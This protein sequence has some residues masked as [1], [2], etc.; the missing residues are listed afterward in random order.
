MTAA[1]DA[2]KIRRAIFA[3]CRETLLDDQA[4]RDLQ[5][6]VTGKASLKDMSP[7]EMEK[8]L[9]AL[10]GRVRRESRTSDLPNG[11]HTAKLRALW[12]SA[13][14]LGVVRDNRDGALAAWICRQTG[15]DAARWATPQQTAA[16]IEALKDW[17]TRDGGV[18]FTPYAQAKGK[19]RH[20]PAARILEALWRRLH[21]AG[22]VRIADDAALHAWVTGFRR[23]S[24]CYTALNAS[25]LN[26]LIK[27]LGEWLKRVSG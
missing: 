11:P 18:E 4:R 12:I 26:Q 22:A 21:A 9:R 3:R 14:W 7:A 10:G 20:V 1:L 27:E 8:V 13:Y 19:P 23:D 2:A 16:C 6:R 17:M 15:I 24:A 25:T 5:L